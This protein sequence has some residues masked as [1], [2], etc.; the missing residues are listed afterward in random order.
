MHPGIPQDQDSTGIPRT[1]APVAIGIAP[2]IRTLGKS[3][4]LT[5]LNFSSLFLQFNFALHL[6]S[7]TS[8]VSERRKETK[9]LIG[10][11][12]IRDA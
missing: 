7:L 4:N 8:V 6:G 12:F 11:P 9:N 1:E 10:I 2:E 5:R 3:Q